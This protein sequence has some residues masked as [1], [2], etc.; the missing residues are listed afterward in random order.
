MGANGVAGKGK[1][2]KLAAESEST[3]RREN[4]S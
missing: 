1:I 4:E 3:R 2:K